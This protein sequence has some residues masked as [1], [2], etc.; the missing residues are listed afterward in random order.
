MELP[1]SQDHTDR[2]LVVRS[3]SAAFA[4]A[5][6]VVLVLTAAAGAAPA[7]GLSFGAAKHYPTGR[8]PV[9]IAVGDFNGDGTQD[10]AT[11]NARG[12]TASVL[13]G[14]GSGGFAA[15][16]DFA[17]GPNPRDVAVGDF[18]GDG[19]QDLATAD[20]GGDTVSVL[21][22]DGSGRSEK[23]CRTSQSSCACVQARS[24]QTMPRR[25]SSLESR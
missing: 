1:W 22:G 17:T 21:L 3:R 14:T 9:A 8:G 2:G 6:L 12:S 20:F 23:R 19:A 24:S 11:A 4:S 5:V 16:T 10:L 7:A 13:L 18:N 15:K 25:R